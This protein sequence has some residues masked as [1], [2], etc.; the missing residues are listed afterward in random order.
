MGQTIEFTVTGELTIKGA[1][2]GEAFDVTVT[3]VDESTVQGTA[4]TTVLRSDHDIGIPSVPGVA[5]VS[6]EV[7][8][9]LVFVAVAGQP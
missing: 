8:L 6:D 7:E 9:T 1:T 2:S 5:N 3:V 4:T